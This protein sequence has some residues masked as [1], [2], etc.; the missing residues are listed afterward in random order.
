MA[1]FDARYGLHCTKRECLPEQVLKFE[2]YHY[3]V[4]YQYTILFI[5]MTF[6]FVDRFFQSSYRRLRAKSIK[7]K[8]FMETVV[9]AHTLYKMPFFVNGN[10][11]LLQAGSFLVERNQC[12]L[13]SMFHHI[14][15][16]FRMYFAA[17][18]SIGIV[19]SQ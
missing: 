18:I 12:R 11:F 10:Y 5:G 15:C 16:I 7:E 3:Y 1:L 4:L 19:E 17:S 13:S 2:S 9:L 8:R 14:P 6:F